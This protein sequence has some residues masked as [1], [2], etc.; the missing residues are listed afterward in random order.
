[1]S[2]SSSTAPQNHSISAVDAADQL[3]VIGDP[4][5]PHE[6][7]DVRPLDDIRRRTPD[8]IPRHGG[9]D[10][11]ACLTGRRHDVDSLAPYPHDD[12]EGRRRTGSD[13]RAG[14]R[15]SARGPWRKGLL[16]RIA[17]AL[18][19]ITTFAPAAR[20]DEPPGAIRG[21]AFIA[22][23]DRPAAGVTLH[24]FD[25]GAAGTT[26]VTHAGGVFLCAVPAG[27]TI[28]AAQDRGEEG[29]PCW[30][31]AQEPG[32][33]TWQPIRFAARS[34]QPRLRPEA[35]RRVA[36]EAGQDDLGERGRADD[37]RGRLPADGR[38]RGPGARRRRCAPGRPPGAGHPG[39]AGAGDAHAGV[40]S[41]STGGPTARGGSACGGSRG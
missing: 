20:A 2:R 41:G 18:L 37:H 6:P 7:G 39:R 38:G 1:M 14:H 23:S 35:R 15:R 31:E 5:P 32:R 29:P 8:V 17:T 19:L 4:V 12:H 22:G 27:V 30:M 26:L 13:R 36:H 25:R 21:K 11:L 16:M 9:S 3:A 10:R 28:P 40:P 34:L 24:F 33:W